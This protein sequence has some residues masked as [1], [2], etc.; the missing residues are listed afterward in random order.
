[1]QISHTNKAHN[2]SASFGA[3]L[4]GDVSICFLC[5]YGPLCFLDLFYLSFKVF[6]MIKLDSKGDGNTC[7]EVEKLKEGEKMVARRL[8]H[9]RGESDC[10]P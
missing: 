3:I 8:S 4:A 10:Y 6:W 2:H 1:M 9:G 7:G 5:Y